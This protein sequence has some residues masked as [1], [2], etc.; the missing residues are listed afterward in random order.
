[1]ERAREIWEAEGLPTLTPKVPW[2]G[3][4]LGYWPEKYAEAARMNLQ[5]ELYKLGE[6]RK[7]EREPFV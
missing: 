6:M 4:E 7:A 2:Y 1:M 5:G 3:Y